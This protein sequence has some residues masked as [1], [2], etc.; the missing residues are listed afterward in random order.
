MSWFPTASEPG[1]VAA[2]RQLFEEIYRVLRSSGRAVISD[3]VSDRPVPEPLQR[4]PQ[5]WSGC[6]SGA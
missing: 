5:L 1:R 4:D 2:K 6:I 3:I